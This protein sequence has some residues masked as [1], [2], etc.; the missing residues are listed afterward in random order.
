MEGGRLSS[1]ARRNASGRA[2]RAAEK[3]GGQNLYPISPEA[4]V[5]HPGNQNKYQKIENSHA[6]SPKQTPF[7]SLSSPIPS[8]RKA[9]N[10]IYA[11]NPNPDLSCIQL[12]LQTQKGKQEKQQRCNHVCKKHCLSKN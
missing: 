2:G 5:T 6:Q 1:P 8:S 9:G 7:S 11:Q 10:S 12:K 4:S 3:Q